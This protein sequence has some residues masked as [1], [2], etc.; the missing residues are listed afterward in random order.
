MTGEAEVKV[1]ERLHRRHCYPPFVEG[2]TKSLKANLPERL[3]AVQSWFRHT[4]GKSARWRP[5]LQR[6]RRRRA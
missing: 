6:L 5:D 3:D 4:F 2:V 1:A